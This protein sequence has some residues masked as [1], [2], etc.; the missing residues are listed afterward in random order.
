[1]LTKLLRVLLMPFRLV[2]WIILEIFSLIGEIYD[3]SSSNNYLQVFFSVVLLSVHCALAKL[4]AGLFGAEQQRAIFMVW[5]Y[6]LI[7]IQLF[8]YFSYSK[9]WI[10]PKQVDYILMQRERFKNPSGTIMKTVEGTICWLTFC[11][12]G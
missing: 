12:H 4:P 9:L 8:G 7:G 3:W 11:Y 1:M 2:F 10:Y 6:V 5:T